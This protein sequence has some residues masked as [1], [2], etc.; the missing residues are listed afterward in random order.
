MHIAWHLPE[1]EQ[2]PSLAADT[3]EDGEGRTSRY[4]GRG[5]AKAVLAEEREM[6]G[7]FQTMKTVLP[8]VRVWTELFDAPADSL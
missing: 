3:V 5:Q 2:V 4:G 7:R 6:R 8:G 1:R